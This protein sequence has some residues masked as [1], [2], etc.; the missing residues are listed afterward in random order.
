MKD[1]LVIANIA[2]LYWMQD[3]LFSSLNNIESLGEAKLV[4]IN[5]AEHK[6]L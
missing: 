4:L 2:W 3:N 1:S 6:N 5:F